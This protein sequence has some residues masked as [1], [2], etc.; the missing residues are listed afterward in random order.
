MNDPLYKQKYY[1][2][3]DYFIELA[4]LDPHIQYKNPHEAL[5]IFKTLLLLLAIGILLQI[6]LN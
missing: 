1:I 4:N 2:C 3:N 5:Q 6:L